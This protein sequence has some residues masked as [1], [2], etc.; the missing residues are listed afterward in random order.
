M[1]R[2]MS[3]QCF[4]LLILSQKQAFIVT[5]V[6]LSDAVEIDDPLNVPNISYFPK[7]D[8]LS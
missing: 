2:V 1:V 3:K 4:P 8:K 6:M 7:N 5:A